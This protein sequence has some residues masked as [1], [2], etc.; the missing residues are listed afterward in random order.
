MEVFIPNFCIYPKR[1]IFFECIPINFDFTVH[2]QFKNLCPKVTKSFISMKKIY[3]KKSSPGNRIGVAWM[4]RLVCALVVHIWQNR[5][6]H[7]MAHFQ[8][9]RLYLCRIRR[10]EF[11]ASNFTVKKK[12]QKTNNCWFTIIGVIFCRGFI[13]SK[14]GLTPS[15]CVRNG[16]M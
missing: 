16:T 2:S 6:S 10:K 13:K 5:F 3:H 9:N 15:I 1:N 14:F 7:N 4:H 11:V 12:K 8:I